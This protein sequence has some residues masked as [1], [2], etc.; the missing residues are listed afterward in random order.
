MD[1]LRD[2]FQTGRRDMLD[3]F[4]ELSALARGA[5]VAECEIS[6]THGQFFDGNVAIK[7][8]FGVAVLLA[9]V[10]S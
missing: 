6:A 10:R 7:R 5:G 9:S 4:A 2:R 8:A 1:E 3:A